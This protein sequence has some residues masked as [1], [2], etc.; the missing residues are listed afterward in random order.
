MRVR[1]MQRRLLMLSAAGLSL[2]GLSACQRPQP[3][4]RVAGI[5]WVGYSPLYLARE[6]NFL[7]HASVR[8]LEL[9]SN[10]AS[11]MALAAG[12]VEA[13]ALT[14]DEFLVAREGQPDLR[15]IMVF[16]ESAGADV[17]MARPDITQPEQLRGRRIGVEDS[18]NGA[19]MLSRTLDA[20]GLRPED[21]FKVSISG[22]TQISSYA[23][24]QVD[25]IVSFEPYATQLSE[26]GATRLLDSRRF[27]GVIVDVLAA[28]SSALADSPEQFRQLLAGYFQAL[29]VLQTNPAQATPLM[30]PTLGINTQELTQ[31]LLGVH[32]L[33]LTDNHA[34]LGGPGAGL[35]PM[36]QSVSTLM[37]RSSLLKTRPRLDGLTD[38]RFLPST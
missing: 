1:N 35:R 24:N 9:N 10:A 21:V 2:A 18:T 26:L 36:A 33:S 4:I 3:L 28:R 16:D 25:A 34:L 14:L 37:L 31:A 22:A 17:V 15:V 5:S 12:Q 7:K 8:L 19:L 6:L 29:T 27:P 11:L 20:A 13:A 32:M 23:S 30:T 38:A